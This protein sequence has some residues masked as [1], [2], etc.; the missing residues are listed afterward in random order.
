MD[1]PGP[2]RLAAAKTTIDPLFSH[3]KFPCSVAAAIWRFRH[4]V[5][6]LPLPLLIH[7]PAGVCACPP[8]KVKIA[9]LALR[10][11]LLS[12][13]ER[14]AVHLSVG[15][16]SLSGNACCPSRE[17]LSCWSSAEGSHHTHLL[18]ILEGA[19]PMLGGLALH[20]PKFQQADAGTWAPAWRP[21]AS[22]SYTDYKL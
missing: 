15:S 3:G 12:W 8:G 11:P 16:S 2:H 13:L 20:A 5:W 1:E 19:F 4:C 22:R 18:Q 17:H 21:S 7:V 6:K 9:S 10:L 14:E